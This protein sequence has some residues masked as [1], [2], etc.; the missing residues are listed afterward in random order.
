MELPR[1]KAHGAPP[2]AAGS[3]Q[4]A[5]SGSRS[6]G[7]TRG[8]E[9]WL[10]HHVA[11]FQSK[12]QALLPSGREACRI[13]TSCATRGAKTRTTGSFK[14][15]QH[16]RRAPRPFF[17]RVSRVSACRISL[18]SKQHFRAAKLVVL[19]SAQRLKAESYRSGSPAARSGGGWRVARRHR[20]IPPPPLTSFELFQLGS[21]GCLLLVSTAAW[22]CVAC[23][24]KP[25]S[26]APLGPVVLP[27][28][29]FTM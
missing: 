25:N 3:P 22:V 14:G 2:T 10:L 16:A 4:P 28:L 29:K 18:G 5:A 15:N 23:D 24:A 6:Y 21:P 20:H 9:P 8:A 7:A 19:L 17:W 11:P 1:V 13:Q 26:L 27:L 12:A